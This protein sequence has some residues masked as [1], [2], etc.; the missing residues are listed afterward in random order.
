MLH[1]LKKYN[2]D[3][4]FSLYIDEKTGLTKFQLWD[5]SGCHFCFMQLLF[6]SEINTIFITETIGYIFEIGE[7]TYE[8]QTI[9]YDNSWSPDLSSFQKI[10]FDRILE[11]INNSEILDKYTNVF[12]TH[13]TY[14]DIMPDGSNYYNLTGEEMYYKLVEEYKLKVSQIE[15]DWMQWSPNKSSIKTNLKLPISSNPSIES[16]CQVFDSDSEI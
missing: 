5:E 14:E 2:D 6:C 13:E 8:S 9:H 15:K 11:T 10:L 1:S 16:I 3:Y 12:M 7:S 4:G